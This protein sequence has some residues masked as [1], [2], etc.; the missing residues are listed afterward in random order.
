MQVVEALQGVLGWAEEGV[1]EA[2]LRKAL[3]QTAAASRAGEQTLI[4]AAHAAGNAGQIGVVVGGGGSGG[5]GEGGGGGG[6]G[7]GSVDGLP[8]RRSML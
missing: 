5:P 3:K 2:V 7:A 4:G 8:W 6:G 1:A